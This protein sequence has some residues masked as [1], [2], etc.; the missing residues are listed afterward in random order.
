MLLSPQERLKAA[1]RI[2]QEAF[3]ERPLSGRR[4]RSGKKSALD[5]W[6]MHFQQAQHVGFIGTHLIT[7]AH[8]VGKHN[9]RQPLLLRLHPATGVVLHRPELFC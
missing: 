9:R 3:K 4:R 1:F 6:T 2:A 5:D 8:D 7:K